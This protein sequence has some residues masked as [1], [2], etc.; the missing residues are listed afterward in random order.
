MAVKIHVVVVFWVMTSNETVPYHMKW[1]FLAYW[2]TNNFP[3]RTLYHVP[4]YIGGDF[5]WELKSALQKIFHGIPENSSRISK[6]TKKVVPLNTV[7][8]D[9]RGRLCAKPVIPNHLNVISTEN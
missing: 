6:E 9:M 7:T 5:A 1:A 2:A 8:D 4:S 3:R